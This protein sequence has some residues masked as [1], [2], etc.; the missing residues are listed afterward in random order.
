MAAEDVFRSLSSHWAGTVAYLTAEDLRLIDETARLTAAAAAG[1][2]DT[3]DART[4]MLRL[5]T[6][7]YDRLPAGHPVSIAISSGVMFAGSVPFASQLPAIAVA[8]D[9]VAALSPAALSPA[10][11]PPDA[12]PPAEVPPAA[13]PDD[14]DEAA[15]WLLA[16]PALT[17][18]Q[19]RD[20]GADP[21]EPGLIR[22]AGPDGRERIRP[23]SSSRPG[24]RS[25]SC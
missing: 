21:A 25:R 6:V 3:R 22:L 5:T 10:E 8:L 18:Q 7:L 23:S 13:V 11:V 19:V 1:T 16:A 14:S 4:A 15:D 20:G 2:G 24:R 17:G 9:A 12:V